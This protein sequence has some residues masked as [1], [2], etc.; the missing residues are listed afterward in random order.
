MRAPRDLLAALVAAEEAAGEQQTFLL[1]YTGGGRELLVAGWPE[2]LAAPST[3]EV[4]DLQERGWVRVTDAEGKGRTFAI[5]VDGRD[6]ASAHA[7]QRAAAEVSAVQLDWSA[8]NPILERTYKAYTDAGAPEFGIETAKVLGGV[9]DPVSSRVAIR[10]LVR[11]G[12]LEAVIDTDVSDI[13]VIVRPMPVTLQLLA[14]WPGG[15]A[16]AA[17]DELMEALDRAISLTADPEERSRLMRV[18]DGLGG[19]AR[20]IVLAYLEKKIG[21]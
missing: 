16:E 10:E 15:T 13:P 9:E 3:E 20:D 4:D 5:T 1:V 17:L 2:D 12:Y 7:R 6:A 8:V 11:A 21:A 19:V 14:G 18:R